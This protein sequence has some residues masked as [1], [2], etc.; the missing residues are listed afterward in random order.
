[1]V[2]FLNGERPKESAAAQKFWDV[3]KDCVEDNRVRPERAP[4]YVKWAKAFVNFP[5]GKRLRHRSRQDIED[6]LA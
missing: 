2:R 3:F 5:P 4:F 1:M 6:F